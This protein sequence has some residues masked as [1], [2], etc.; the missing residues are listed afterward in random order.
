MRSQKGGCC[1]LS[2]FEALGTLQ[3]PAAKS[4]KPTEGRAVMCISQLARLMHQRGVVQGGESREDIGGTQVC[5]AL[6][7]PALEPLQTPQMI[8]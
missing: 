7:V 6:E 1:L 2:P 4:H 8:R 3:T 5:V